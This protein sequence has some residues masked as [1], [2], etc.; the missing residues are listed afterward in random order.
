MQIVVSC[1]A[2]F[3]WVAVPLD[4][5]WNDIIVIVKERVYMDQWFSDGNR[6]SMEAI[7][8]YEAW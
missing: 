1:I 3:Y 7:M 2:Y 5:Y 4:G 8:V 6:E